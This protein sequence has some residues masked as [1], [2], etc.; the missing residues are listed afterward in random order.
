MKI[1]EK[2]HFSTADNVPLNS[3]TKLPLLCL[4]K[5]LCYAKAVH[6]VINPRLWLDRPTEKI[7]Q[8]HKD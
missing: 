7:L 5:R 4:R 2:M 8:N 3:S 1:L 6:F